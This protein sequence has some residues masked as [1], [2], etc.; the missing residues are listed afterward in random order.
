VSA[1]DA[2]C[3]PSEALAALGFCD[4]AAKETAEDSAGAAFA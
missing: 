3:E 1:G 4:V 2:N